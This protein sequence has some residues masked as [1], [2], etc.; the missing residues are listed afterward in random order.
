VA[1]RRFDVADVVEVLRLWDAGK[2][3]REIARSTGM[4][5]NRVAAITRK[6][7]AAFARGAERVSGVEWA[8]RVRLLFGT[9]VGGRIGDQERRI[10][11]FHGEIVERLE[12]S[13]V[14]TVWQRMRD[15]RGLE[16]GLTTF[17]QYVRK[18]IG[19][20]RPNDVRV[21]KTPP[22]PGEIAEVDFGRMGM[23]PDPITGRQR[24][25]QAFVMALA[26]SR[27]IFVWPVL[28]CD[29]AAWVECHRRAFDFFG[30]V[31]HQIRL[32]NL[33]TGVLKADI[34]DPQ[35][36]RTYR[37]FGDHY[38]IVIDPCRAGKPTDKPQV[39][40][41]MPY[42]RDSWWSGKEFWSEPSMQE[43][44]VRWAST[45]ADARPHR[46]L[47][48]TVGS[49]FAE[50]ELP[51]MRPLP[52][53][54]FEMAWWAKPTVHPDCHV[55]VDARFYSIPWQYIGRVI[56][57]RVGERVVRAYA[58]GELIKTHILERGK[59]RYTDA[60]D[61]PPDKIAFFQRTPVWCRTEAAKLG[62]H[63]AVLVAQLLPERAPLYLLRQAQGIVRLA[64]TYES[65]RIDA[66]CSRALDTDPSLMTV[67]N[68]LK[69]GL[70]LRR[71]EPP[72]PQLASGGY[73]HGA[74]VLLEG[75][76]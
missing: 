32:D 7:S 2:S 46:I 26:F 8:A 61:Y 27:R 14:T 44:A 58:D 50:R 28:K 20:V 13:T 34:Y 36:N 71:E 53:E 42:V 59:R 17:R 21:R 65:A 18:R 40:R 39:E 24:V 3:N 60:A 15:E 38:G 63:V 57:V 70:D 31:P 6:A 54:P 56:D 62:E 68:I 43:D 76:W 29:E 9:R 5:R 30:A 48:G 72:P 4:G 11:E 25:V 67:R 41:P 37:E 75:P 69:K 22:P 66:A 49:V 55:Q 1:G 10:A 73:L 12:H 23:W 51:A 52:S 47:D 19:M 16:V 35:C 45:I 33:K 74:G 64:E